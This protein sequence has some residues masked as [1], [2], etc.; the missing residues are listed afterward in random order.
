MGA[1]AFPHAGTHTKYINIA[2]RWFY[3]G[4]GRDRDG[5]VALPVGHPLIFR[6][7]GVV[8]INIQNVRR[9]PPVRIV[10]PPVST[11]DAEL[12]V[13]MGY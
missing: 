13:G 2:L 9:P 3:P 1:L 7:R 5:L 6:P 12:S 10:H 8:Q 4:V 11:R